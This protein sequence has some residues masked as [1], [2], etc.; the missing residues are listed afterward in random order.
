MAF[1][2]G[3]GRFITSKRSAGDVGASRRATDTEVA[4]PAPSNV[5]DLAEARERLDGGCRL[6]LVEAREQAESHQRPPADP[7]PDLGQE[8]TDLSAALGIVEAKLAYLSGAA[9]ERSPAGGLIGLMGLGAAE[10]REQIPALR[11][12]M[13]DAE[14]GR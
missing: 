5:H 7:T 14:S 9:P 11:A 6:A 1:A 8:I 10:V 3:H 13:R 12:A 4:M 2:H